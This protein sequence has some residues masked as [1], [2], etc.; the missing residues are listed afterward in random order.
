MSKEQ[1]KKTTKNVFI[2]T[3]VGVILYKIVVDLIWPLIA[4]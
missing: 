3:I 2:L 4:G 1:T